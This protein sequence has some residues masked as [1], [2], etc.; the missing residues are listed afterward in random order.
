MC[1]TEDYIP[2]FCLSEIDIGTLRLFQLIPGY[3]SFS[4]D[5]AKS[6]YITFAVDWEWIN[7]PSTTSVDKVVK[8]S[9]LSVCLCLG[10]L[11]D[12][13]GISRF[14]I[15][16]WAF[17]IL[18]FPTKK[19]EIHLLSRGK[20]PSVILFINNLPIIH[21]VLHRHHWTKINVH[22]C[23]DGITLAVA[24]WLLPTRRTDFFFFLFES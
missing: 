10:A 2:V 17:N 4:G 5:C 20:R 7:V 13:A 21:I 1:Q 11:R 24:S 9:K 6:N 19:Y 16:F 23:E 12:S 8:Q 3:L 14:I 18:L 22:P 15:N